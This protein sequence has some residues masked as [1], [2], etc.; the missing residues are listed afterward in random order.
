MKKFKLL[1]CLMVITLICTLIPSFS[2]TAAAEEN[3]EE[4]LIPY[5]HSGE[6][7]FSYESVL[8]VL[9]RSYG[10]LNKEWKTDDFPVSNITSID[11]LTYMPMT[12]DEQNE[13]LEQVDFHQILKFNLEEQ[14]PECVLTAIEELEKCEPVL[15]AEPDFYFEEFSTVP[16][17][18][19]IYSSYYGYYNT[20]FFDAWDIETG[21]SNVKV[22]IIDTG[23]ANISDL[24]GNVNY[25]LGYSFYNN[26]SV[27]WNDYYGTYGHGTQV[28]SV[29]GAIGN[30]SVGIC[31][32]CWNVTLVPFQIG[33]TNVCSYHI[34]ALQR[35]QYLNIPIVNISSGQYL[36]DV[37]LEYEI[38]NYTGLVVCAAGNGNNIIGYD[39]D[40][41]NY[42][43]SPAGLP[44]DN[45]ISVA[46]SNSNDYLTTFSNYGATNVDLAAPGDDVYVLNTSGNYTTNDGT[47]FSAPMVAGAA[48][49][50]L[51]YN[52][53]L[54]TLELKE[55]LLKSVDYQS[56]YSGKMVS[57]G[58]LNVYKALQYVKTP[59]QVQNIVI[60]ANKQSSSGLSSFGFDT[61]YKKNYQTFAGLING[62]AIP[63]GSSM[64]YSLSTDPYY[65]TNWKLSANYSGSIIY[66]TGSLFTLRFNSNLNTP[67][68]AFYNSINITNSSNL[69]YLIAVLG[70]VNND[71]YVDDTDRALVLSYIAHTVTFNSQQ[72]LAGDVNSDGYV[73]VSD[74]VKIARY[75]SREINSFY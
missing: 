37:A 38:S 7:D 19:Y 62:S 53:N 55:A 32:A 4:V 22:G 50:L 68:S 27:T 28:A 60:R 57:E 21:S 29:V 3:N 12:E 70:D 49:L 69:P 17:D 20:K 63:S 48:A 25:S 6:N 43:L 39:I 15:S 41:P 31:G 64:S 23:I 73:D 10:S 44:N 18:P 67:Y 40:D 51:S 47:S 36:H 16:N 34:S 35:A 13:Y 59:N 66:S 30:N 52:P 45:I 54:T 46:A 42:Y 71:G 14:T 58:R 9:K 75:T 24:S 56:S 26:D 72:L 65:T 33:P 1:S 8:V 74:A 61:I 11:D 5:V 2:L